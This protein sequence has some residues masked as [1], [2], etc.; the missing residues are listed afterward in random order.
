[1]LCEHGN[2]KS[3]HSEPGSLKAIGIAENF[4]AVYPVLKRYRMYD[5]SVR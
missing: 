5:F 3:I 4:H 1:M 2:E